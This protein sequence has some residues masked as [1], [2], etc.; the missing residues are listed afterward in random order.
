MPP[1][2]NVVAGQYYIYYTYHSLGLYTTRVVAPYNSANSPYLP[3]PLPQSLCASCVLL[4]LLCAIRMLPRK[5]ASYFL[6]LVVRDHISHEHFSTLPTDDFV[7]HR[8]IYCP[9]T[10]FQQGIPR[11]REYAYYC[12]YVNLPQIRGHG[13]GSTPPIT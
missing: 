4:M 9:R 12:V 7:F 5:Q 13:P 2:I 6:R 11:I 3:A 10:H 8:P 1:Q